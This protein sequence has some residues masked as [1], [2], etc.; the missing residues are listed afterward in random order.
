M[1]ELAV[2]AMCSKVSVYCLYTLFRRKL[3]HP[4]VLRELYDQVSASCGG[5]R[6]CG[7]VCV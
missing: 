4:D 2:L 1:C 7:F 6:G 3:V 5:A